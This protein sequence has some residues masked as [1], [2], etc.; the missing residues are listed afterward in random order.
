[1]LLSQFIPQ[2]ISYTGRQLQPQWACREWGLLGDVVVSFIGP[3]DVEREAMVDLE[4]VRAG[5]R[6]YS[7]LMLHF[8]IEH[9]RPDLELAVARQRLFMAIVCE[10]LNARLGRVQFRRHGDDLFDG[11]HKLS[12]SIAAVSP[13][14]ALIHVGLNIRTEGVPVPACGLAEYGI[15][16]AE[17]AVE[18]MTAYREEIEGMERARCKARPV[19]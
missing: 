13:V 17:F 7:P 5:A 18:A 1:M 15:E 6:I 14:S 10:R 4:D 19:L 11:E 2:K 9:F 8:I 16:A 3:C 12:I